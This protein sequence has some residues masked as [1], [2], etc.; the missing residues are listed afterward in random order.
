MFDPLPFAGLFVIVTLTLTLFSHVDQCVDL[1][2]VA[3]C[4]VGQV[5]EIDCDLCLIY[6]SFYFSLPTPSGGFLT[7]I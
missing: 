3:V 4:V 5:L 7:G 2:S 6:C 1:L